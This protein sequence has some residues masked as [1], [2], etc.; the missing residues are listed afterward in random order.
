[1][2]AR[3]G[4][5][6]RTVSS[7][8]GGSATFTTTSCCMRRP[9]RLDHETLDASVTPA[10]APSP[11]SRTRLDVT[12]FSAPA[13]G[14]G[15]PSPREGDSSAAAPGRCARV[16][17]HRGCGMFRAATFLRRVSGPVVVPAT[18]SAHHPDVRGPQGRRRTPC[19]RSPRARGRNVTLVPADAPP[20]G[21][22]A[23]PGRRERGPVHRD[24]AAVRAAGLN[25]PRHGY[26]HDRCS[27][28]DVH[29]P[30]TSRRRCRE[31]HRGRVSVHRSGRH[32]QRVHVVGG[33]AGGHLVHAS[34]VV[35]RCGRA[36]RNVRCRLSRRRHS[37]AAAQRWLPLGEVRGF[38]GH[39]GR[40]FESPTLGRRVAKHDH[41]VG[42]RWS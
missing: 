9:G 26:G 39:S 25:D 4:R 40:A 33:A 5:C 34:R 42:G 21:K 29:P 13:D 35:H 28:H 36:R 10:L 27:R 8:L 16:G 6:R 12:K 20:A 23:G 7:R 37:W 2:T 18:G 31:H 14:A 1:M 30:W 41:A 3:S 38:V 15:H 11:R 32:P 17:C 24:R 22:Q 19:G